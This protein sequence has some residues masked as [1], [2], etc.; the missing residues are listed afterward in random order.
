MQAA[1]NGQIKNI[2]RGEKEHV[3]EDWDNC[4]FRIFAGGG[5]GVASYAGVGA[6]TYVFHLRFGMASAAR[7]VGGI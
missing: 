5:T 6:G 7:A 2:R 4:G 1:L 3:E